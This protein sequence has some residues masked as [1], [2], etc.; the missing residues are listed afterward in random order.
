MPCYRAR[1]RASCCIRSTCWV[2]IRSTELAFFPGMDLSG[3]RKMALFRKVLRALGERYR[4]V[5]MSEHARAIL[6][7]PSLPI[8]SAVSRQPSAVEGSGARDLRSLTDDG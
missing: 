1:S 5:A 6:G 4:L 3:A 2:E 7:R 8:M